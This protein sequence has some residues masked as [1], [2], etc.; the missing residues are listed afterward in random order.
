M[1]DANSHLPEDIAAEKETS[2]KLAQ[3]YRNA[4]FGGLRKFRALRQKAPGIVAEFVLS[5]VISVFSVAFLFR[6]IEF[7]G[8]LQELGYTVKIIVVIVVCFWAARRIWRLIGLANRDR[9]RFVVSNMW[10]LALGGLLI[11]SLVTKIF[12]PE[13]VAAP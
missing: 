1:S 3:E 6:N 4:A 12:Y 13:F 7:G 2:R 8:V 10:G 11:A 9:C 5:V